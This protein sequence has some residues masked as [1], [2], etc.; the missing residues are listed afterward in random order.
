MNFKSKFSAVAKAKSLLRQSALLMLLLL[1][2]ASAASAS[3]SIVGTW[4]AG[5]GVWYT[6]F[7]DG[8]YAG[9]VPPCGNGC[10]FEQGPYAGNLFKRNVE[11]L[12][13]VNLIVRF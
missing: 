6:F 8:N 12:I 9:W 13:G 5:N 3:N 10:G 11:D 4:S 2:W 1:G 7:G